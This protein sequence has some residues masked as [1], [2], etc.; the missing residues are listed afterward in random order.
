MVRYHAIGKDSYMS[1]KTIIISTILIVMGVAMVVALCAPTASKKDDI[2][3]YP[4]AK[5][6]SKDGKWKAYLIGT[7]RKG[8]INAEALTHEPVG[9]ELLEGFPNGILTYEGN[10]EGLAKNV[11]VVATFTDTAGK[12]HKY[13]GK[14]VE[15]ISITD[16][17]D[18]QSI[19]R[20][21]IKKPNFFW[22][23]NIDLLPLYFNQVD[24]VEVI[25]SWTEGKEN[26][27]QTLTLDAKAE[28]K[29]FISSL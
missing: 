13:E 27:K 19:D 11:S 25:V 24:G 3:S 23:M 9:E 17:Y 5:A 21:I 29:R 20:N 4:C 14:D 7:G 2:S 26:K 22:F 1:K 28:R 6:V 15:C 12:I 18:L 16:N 10:D 8:P